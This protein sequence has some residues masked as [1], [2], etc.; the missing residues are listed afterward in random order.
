MVPEGQS[1]LLESRRKMETIQQEYFNEVNKI[2]NIEDPLLQVREY[3][4]VINTYRNKMSKELNKSEDFVYKALRKTSYFNNP[5]FKRA[6]N[7]ESLEVKKEFNSNDNYLKLK[8]DE[9]LR[10]K[11]KS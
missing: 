3:F 8:I 9:I 11:N 7:V 4:S 1:V 2:K 10:N 5:D 6:I